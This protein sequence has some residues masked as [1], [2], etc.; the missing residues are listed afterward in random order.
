M[1]LV[2]NTS[3]LLKKKDEMAVPTAVPQYRRIVDEF[4]VLVSWAV[5]VVCP[6][7]CTRR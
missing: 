5:L 3:R 7:A 2:G 6:L 1:R 4:G